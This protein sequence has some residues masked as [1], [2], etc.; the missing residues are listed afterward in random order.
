MPFLGLQ[1]LQIEALGGVVDVKADDVATRVEIHVETV[2]DLPGFH[3]RF[4]PEFHVEAV[5]VGVVVQ[6][7][8]SSSR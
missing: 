3:A 7:H 6:L 1:G 4:A 5:G 8:C 2:S